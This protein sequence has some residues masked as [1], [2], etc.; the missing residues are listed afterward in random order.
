MWH[1]GTESG[2]LSASNWWKLANLKINYNEETDFK[3]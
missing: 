1:H 2:T 3:E